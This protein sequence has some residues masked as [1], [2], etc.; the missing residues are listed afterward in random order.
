[1]NYVVFLLHNT[2]KNNLKKETV[3]FHLHIGVPSAHICLDFLYLPLDGQLF[4]F[5]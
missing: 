4:D 2:L 1:M 3:Q 5:M